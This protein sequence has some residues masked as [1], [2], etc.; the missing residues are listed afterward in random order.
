MMKLHCLWMLVCVF[1]IGLAAVAAWGLA[2]PAKDGEFETL[3]YKDAG[4][5]TLLYRLLEPRDDPAEG[6]RPLL[7][8]LHGAGERGSDNQAQLKWGRDMMRTA[9][10]KHGCF[11]VVPQCPKGKKWAEV[12]WSKSTHKMPKEPSESMRLL[13]ELMAKMQKEFPIDADRLYVMGLSMGGYGTWNMI[14]RYPDM[15]AAAVPICGGGDDTAANRIKTP[16]WAFHGDK[17]GAV[18]V[19]RSQNM[20]A[21]I[22]A[23]GGKPKYTEYPDCGHNAWSPAFADPELLGWLFSHKRTGK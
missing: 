22:K 17:D 12:D 6:K 9:A 19:G 13:L 15:F 20:I 23:A 5:T 21:A 18:P 7:V 8:F 10:R 2:E 4:G 1:S 14:Q 11:V 16:V 3:E